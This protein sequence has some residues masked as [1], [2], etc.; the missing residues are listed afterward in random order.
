MNAHRYINST[1][2][3]PNS[4]V[5]TSKFEYLTEIKTQESNLN[6]TYIL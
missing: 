2:I 5:R 4:Q 3:L 6:N 1:F